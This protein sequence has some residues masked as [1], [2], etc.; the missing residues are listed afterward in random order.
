MVEEHVFDRLT[1]A[2]A[3]EE[4]AKEEAQTLVDKF[5]RAAERLRNWQKVD[6]VGRNEDGTRFGPLPHDCDQNTIRI[7]DVPD[8]MTIY[9]AVS[10]WNVASGEVHGLRE[11]LTAEQRQTLGLPAR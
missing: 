3:T 1:K 7:M 10:K 6:F 8:L 5:L 11:N 9:G 2:K 4:E